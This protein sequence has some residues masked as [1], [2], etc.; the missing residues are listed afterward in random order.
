M[1]SI[2]KNVASKLV[3]PVPDQDQTQFKVDKVLNQKSKLK[4]TDIFEQRETS[5]TQEQVEKNRS[6]TVSKHPKKSKSKK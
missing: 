3:A 5:I 2:P 6:K 1:T 4:K